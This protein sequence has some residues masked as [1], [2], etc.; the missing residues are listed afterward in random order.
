MSSKKQTETTTVV[1]PTSESIEN[2]KSRLER[3][4]TELNRKKSLA[5]RRDLFIE[6]RNLLENYLEI[7][8]AEDS[9]GDFVKQNAKITF[10][11]DSPTNSYNNREEKFTV[12]IPD[13]IESYVVNLLSDINDAI[14]GIEKELIA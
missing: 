2:A 10:S 6:K 3:E 7:I 5:D 14:D 11:Y 1:I 4:L 8:A 12:T 13:L 9:N